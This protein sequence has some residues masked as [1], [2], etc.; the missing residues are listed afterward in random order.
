MRTRQ[1]GPGPLR[2]H[3]KLIGTG[4]TGTAPSPMQ[5]QLL[6]KVFSP[7]PGCTLYPGGQKC[8]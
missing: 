2:A 1:K 7:V 8:P 3:L 4:L 6:Q 5:A